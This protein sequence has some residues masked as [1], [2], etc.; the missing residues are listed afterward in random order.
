[1]TIPPASA[2][3]PPTA[4]AGPDVSSAPAGASREGLGWLLEDFRTQVPG[5]KGAF[6]VPR[7]GLVL[8]AVGLT[9]DEADH[10]AAVAAALYSAG[11]AAGKITSPPA[12][13][14]QQ[15]IVQ[16]DAQYL[17]LMNTPDQHPDAPA[18]A[19]EAGSGGSAVV[20]CV[21]GVLAGPD[22]Q[23]GLVAHGMTMLIESVARH[24]VT[25]TRTTSGAEAPAPEN[26]GA[27]ETTGDGTGLQSEGRGD[28]Q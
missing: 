15:I 13:D 19:T 2:A 16:H 8:A 5:I 27:P 23:T 20:G 28:E 10:A 22:A 6:L 26:T 7:D 18:H 4:L 24:M 14:V 1:M 25:A 3:L 17:I 12:G 21:L 9:T 11:G